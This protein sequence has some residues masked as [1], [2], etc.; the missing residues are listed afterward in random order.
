MIII[1]QDK[2]TIFNFQ[3]IMYVEIAENKK[4]IRC[5]QKKSKFMVRKL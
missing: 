2:K 5:Q 1:S 4:T 3:N